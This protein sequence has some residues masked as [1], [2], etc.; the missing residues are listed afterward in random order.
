MI[1]ESYPAQIT[2]T[3]VEVIDHNLLIDGYLALID[4]VYQ[5]DSGLN[6]EIT[7]IALDTT[8]WVE[9]TEIEKEIIITQM[10]EIYEMDIIEGTFDELA[11]QGLIDEENLY[12]PEGVLIKI[13]EMVYNDK[14]ET[15]TCKIDKWRGGLGAI[16][17]DA[18]A[19][20]L[21]EEWVI[22]RDNMWIS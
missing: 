15:I 20:Y 3:A 13:K 19:K 4:D 7:M 14:K 12:F 18:T 1:A 21:N 2:A 6:S 9:L 17:W 11:E 8:G 10:K 5:E 22:T 16:G